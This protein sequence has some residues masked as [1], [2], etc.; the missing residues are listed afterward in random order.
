MEE[1]TPVPCGFYDQLEA[2][3]TLG[4]P[5]EI[6]F[7]R[8]ERPAAVKGKIKD[9]YT[10]EGAEYLKMD[11]GMELKLDKITG[12]NGIQPFPFC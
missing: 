8:D 7:L 3:A 1:Y 4:T 11:N 12:V 6:R 9:L 2:F 10:R 5:C